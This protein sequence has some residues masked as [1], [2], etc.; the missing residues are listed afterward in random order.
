MSGM[1]RNL[2]G[3]YPRG[4]PSPR[5]VHV[6]PYPTRFHGSINTRPMFSLPFK[7]QPQS[8]FKPDDFSREPPPVTTTQGLGTLQYNTRRGIFRPGGYGGGIFDGDI[9]GLG[10][11]ADSLPWSTYSAD[12]AEFQKDLNALLRAEGKPTLTEDGR[13]GKD[14]CNACRGIEAC[15]PVPTNCA[16]QYATPA[17]SPVVAP[18]LTVNQSAMLPSPGMSSTTKNALIFVGAGAAAIGIAYFVMKR[19]KAA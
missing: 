15:R 8:V 1:S 12:T 10:Y 9:S 4:V 7:Y 6:H 16:Q 17:P 18:P 14:T 11:T 19:K 5:T 13:L 3:P 2:M